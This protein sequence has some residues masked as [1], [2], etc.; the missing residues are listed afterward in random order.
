[1]N[2][3]R[4]KFRFW[5]NDLQRYAPFDNTTHTWN[6]DKSIQL[7][8]YN[9]L[10]LAGRFTAE[11]C[12]GLKDKNGILIY[13]GDVVHIDN[14]GDFRIGVDYF[15]VRYESINSDEVIYLASLDKIYTQATDIEIIGNINTDKG[16]EL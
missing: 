3:E 8:L 14:K 1:M 10:T 2:N 5:D 12:T 7:D 13:E 11:Q 16:V 6:A 4:F 15:G 9:M